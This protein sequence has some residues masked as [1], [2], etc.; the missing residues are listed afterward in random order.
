MIKRLS[1][2][3][4]LA[5]TTS[6]FVPLAV[7][8]TTNQPIGYCSDDFAAAKAAGF[9]FAEVRIREFVKLSDAEFAKFVE[10]AHA[11]GLPTLTGYWFLPGELKIV[12]PN[13]QTNEVNAYLE[14]ALA[15]C[16][17]IGVKYI[18][19]GSGDARR[20]PEDFP[21]EK[22]FEQLV[23]LAKR[24]AP[25][26]EKRGMMIVAEPLRK[27]ESNTINS[28][29]EALQWVEAVNHPN[30]QMLVDIYHMNEENEDAAII[31]K[32]GSHIRHVHLSNPMGRV[33]PLHA[34]EFDYRPFFKALNRINYHGP[35]SIEAR[36]S[37]LSEEG[38]RAIE[39]IR[40]ARAT[41]GK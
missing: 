5:L 9:D 34:E 23:T 3:A 14:K 6:V 25:E 33:F 19:W 27:K 37:K 20:A 39:F 16:Q 1:A 24:L 41:A 12:G 7:G 38:P 36:T 35:I 29:A 11:T 31:A 2:F 28:A 22:A 30:F 21:R 18:V 17:K 4:L 32:A 15:R 8:Q 13:V 26:A 10:Q 40:S